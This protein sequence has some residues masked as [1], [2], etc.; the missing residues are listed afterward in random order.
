MHKWHITTS[1]NLSRGAAPYGKE[2]KTR[3]E[4]CIPAQMGKLADFVGGQSKKGG[5]RWKLVFTAGGQH[6]MYTPSVTL[7]VALHHH[8]VASCQS[9]QGLLGRRSYIVIDLLL[10]RQGT[11]K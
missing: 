11:G 4:L 6:A 5:K 1:I 9:M 8:G 3:N 10:R 2:C 7:L